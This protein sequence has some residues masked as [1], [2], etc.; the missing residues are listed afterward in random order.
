MRQREGAALFDTHTHLNAAAYDQDRAAVIKQARQQGV[1]GMVVVGFDLPSSRSAI[2]VAREHGLWATAG[3]QPHYAGETG[4]QELAQLRSL[5]QDP[6]IVALGEIG[7]D[8]YRDRAPRREQRQ[9]FRA[10]LGL[11]RELDL[12][13][14]IH[15]RESFADLLV[16]L[17]EAGSGLRGVMHCYSG[18]WPQARDF[19]AL[20]LYISIAGP[21]TYP[22]ASK[23]WQVAAQV[24]LDRLLLETDCPWLPPQSHRGKRN[25]PAYLSETAA[26]VAE[27]RELPLE[28]LAQ[29]TTANAHRLFR[30]PREPS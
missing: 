21:V 16:D 20:G 23:T 5:A 15:S 8:Y 30:L 6:A 18:T 19:L 10:Q 11:A 3:I 22:K 7:L 9:L 13:V 25:E 1:P 17:L 12:P 26:R 28:A 27:L 4:P 29:A 2:T 24:P 14:V